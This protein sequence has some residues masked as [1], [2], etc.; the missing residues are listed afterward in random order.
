[1]LLISSP[2]WLGPVPFIVPV[3]KPKSGGLLLLR[4]V[5]PLPR[6]DAVYFCSGAY[7]RRI[8]PLSYQ[9]DLR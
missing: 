3:L 8:F 9:G 6:R 1:L 2:V 4:R 5:T 7:K